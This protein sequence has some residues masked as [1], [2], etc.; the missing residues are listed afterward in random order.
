MAVRQRI[1]SAI[2]LPMPGNRSCISSTA[3]IGVRARRRRKVPTASALNAA[4]RMSGAI[5]VH[6][7]G[8]FRPR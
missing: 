4:E 2:Q 6:Q 8:G 1:S 3:L 7:S 5:R